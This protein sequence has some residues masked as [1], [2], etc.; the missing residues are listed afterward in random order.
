MIKTILFDFDGT[1]ANTLPL[2]TFCFREV[3]GTYVGRDFT[4]DEIVEMFGPTEEGMLANRIPETSLNEAITS[5]YKLYER[6]HTRL[7]EEDRSVSHM[8]HT[9]RNEGYRLGI[10]TGKGRR[11]LDISRRFLPFCDWFDAVVTGD[12]VACPKP[13]PEGI[14][15]CL[16]TLDAT[17]DAA[18]YVGDSDSDIQAG[19]AAGLITVG[20]QWMPNP[21]ARGFETEP[22]YVFTEIEAFLHVI[23]EL[24]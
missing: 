22:D 21:Q 8:V 17:P 20:A 7:V 1:L 14:L 16:A 18:V 6:H 24:S 5:F 4:D 23:Q 11:S 2:V 9:L 12:D 13:D 19:R 10:C 15:S 3:F